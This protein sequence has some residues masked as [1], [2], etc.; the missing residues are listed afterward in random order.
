MDF[1][2]DAVLVAGILYL[3]P[4]QSWDSAVGA[5]AT[6]LPGMSLAAVRSLVRRHL[7]DAADFDIETLP[8]VPAPAPVMPPPDPGRP[9]AWWRRR[10]HVAAAVGLALLT[11]L[12][13]VA[14]VEVTRGES[15]L[16]SVGGETD[17]YGF[18]DLAPALAA[19]DRAGA[20]MGCVRLDEPGTGGCLVGAMCT[21]AS[22]SESTNGSAEF[23]LPGDGGSAQV[24]VF[25]TRAA[26][27]RWVGRRGASIPNADVIGRVVVWGSEVDRVAHWSGILAEASP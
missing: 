21:V 8:G 3:R 9:R 23:A 15:S 12:T 11:S 5:V 1:G 10:G 18:E 24:R 17:D 2:A 20:V 19:L 14:G 27:A 22:I 4:G 13:T 16:F 26:A 25:P 7:P 6:V